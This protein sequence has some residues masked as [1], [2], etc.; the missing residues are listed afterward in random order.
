M[1]ENSRLE[2]F[3]VFKHRGRICL[4]IEL[5][6]FSNI[7]RELIEGERIPSG[8]YCCGYVEV[9]A[10][11]KGKSYNEF[12]GRIDTDELTFSGNFKKLIE[13]KMDVDEDIWFFGFDSAHYWNNNKPDS[14]TFT[15]VKGK[16]IELCNE[17]I[18]K[19]I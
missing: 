1:E 2:R 19:G 12:I 9:S 17:M 18:K 6:D 14:K 3:H 4:V 11:N 16:T 5:K 10:K 15:F 7:A 13:E 8:T